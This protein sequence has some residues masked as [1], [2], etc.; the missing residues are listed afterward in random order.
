M[1]QAVPTPAASVTQCSCC[2]GSR[3]TPRDAVR[4]SADRIAARV[5]ASGVEDTTKDEVRSG[6]DLVRAAAPVRNA[7]GVVVVSSWSRFMS[8][9]R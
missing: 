5:A 7:V 2:P 9:R 6:G 8:R 4:A 1:Y 3:S